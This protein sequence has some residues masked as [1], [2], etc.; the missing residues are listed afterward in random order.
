MEN[1]MKRLILAMIV[2]LSVNSCKEQKEIS[3][4]HILNEFD[5]NNVTDVT[6]DLLLELKYSNLIITY[7][8]GEKVVM[9]IFNGDR[10]NIEIDTIENYYIKKGRLEQIGGL[11]VGL[12]DFAI[13]CKK[14]ENKKT[15]YDFLNFYKG[16]ILKDV[17]IEHPK[18]LT[19][20]EGVWIIYYHY[21][22][23]GVPSCLRINI[24]G[25]EKEYTKYTSIYQIQV[26]EDNNGFMYSFTDCCD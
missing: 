26:D 17:D 23:Q 21:N 6:G 20:E 3:N 5:E 9:P 18:C 13:S 2:L 12:G 24:A 25:A 14:G 10:G 22:N 19:N 4:M 16:N 8:T 1:F 7:K 11:K 15:F